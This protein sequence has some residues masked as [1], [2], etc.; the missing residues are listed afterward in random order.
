MQLQNIVDREEILATA[1]DIVSAHV[2]C[3]KVSPELMCDTLGKVYETLYTLSRSDNP[4][5]YKEL[6]NVTPAP[7]AE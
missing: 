1:A 6:L 7:E 3:S 2:S 4:L 5:T